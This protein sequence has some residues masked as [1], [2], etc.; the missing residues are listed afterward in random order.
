VDAEIARRGTVLVPVAAEQAA[1]QH[2]AGGDAD[3]EFSAGAWMVAM[4][5]VRA[6]RPCMPDTPL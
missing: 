6:T 1:R 4:L 2:A 3:A 5:S